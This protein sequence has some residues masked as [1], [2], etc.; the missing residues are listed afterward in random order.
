MKKFTYIY[1]Y[2]TL[3]A[4]ALLGLW[5]YITKFTTWLD[6]VIFPP[7]E[8]VALAF[9]ISIKDGLLTITLVFEHVLH[10]FY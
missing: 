10:Q 3:I 9:G 1:I 5:V 7:P 2:S 4:I 8:I 6:P